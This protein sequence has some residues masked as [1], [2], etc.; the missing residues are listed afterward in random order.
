MGLKGSGVT[1]EKLMRI[2]KQSLFFSIVPGGWNWSGVMQPINRKV[3]FS[4]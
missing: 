4:W 1:R 2:D 3:S